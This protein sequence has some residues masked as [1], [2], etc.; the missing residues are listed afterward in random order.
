M[1][2][3]RG[4]YWMFN[5]IS[6]ELSHPNFHNNGSSKFIKV[7]HKPSVP[8]V[9]RRKQRCRLVDWQQLLD[10]EVLCNLIGYL[11]DNVFN[12]LLYDRL[13]VCDQLPGVFVQS[14]VSGFTCDSPAELQCSTLDSFISVTVCS[15]HQVN[16]TTG[17]SPIS[18]VPLS[19]AQNLL[20]EH[21]HE[22][23]KVPRLP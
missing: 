11:L 10:S 7:R 19:P 12:R 23:S 3:L 1:C 9:T 22:L 20:T 14:S 13:H 16:V 15:P 18:P 4:T 8:V 17:E 2:L 21:E 6:A 5:Y